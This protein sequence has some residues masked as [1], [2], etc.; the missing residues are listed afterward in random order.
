MWF[1]EEPLTPIE[2]FLVHK[3]SYLEENGSLDF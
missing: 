3:K 2:L 1:H